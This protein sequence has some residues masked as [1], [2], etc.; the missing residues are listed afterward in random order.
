MGEVLAVLGIKG[1]DAGAHF[2]CQFDL[3]PYVLCGGG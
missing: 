1:R 2:E 3:R